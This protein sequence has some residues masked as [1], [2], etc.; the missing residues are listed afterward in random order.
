MKLLANLSWI[1]I[2]LFNFLIVA[3]YG[4]LM[5]YKIGFEFPY[6][7]QKSLLLAHFN[8]GFSGWIS[9]LLMVLLVK[10]SKER[11]LDISKSKFT[12][13][14]TL[15]LICTYG[16]LISF[17]MQGYGLYS[18][19]FSGIASILSLIFS[20]I[21]IKA[22]RKAPHFEA[23]KWF[24]AALIFNIIAVFGFIYLGYLMVSKTLILD[25]YLA[26]LYGYFHFQ[27]NGWFLFVCFGLLIDFL[28]KHSI[29]I[30]S[31]KLIFWLFALSCIPTFGL[32]VLWFDIPI[33]IYTI[34]VIASIAQF[35]GWMKFVIGFVSGKYFSTLNFNWLSKLFMLIVFGA[36]SIKICLQ[37]G[38]TIPEVSKFAFG[39]RPI[40]IA[41][42]HLVFLAI[43]SSFLLAY[44]YFSK[45]IT[46]GKLAISGF[47]V[48]IIGMALNEL[49]LAIQGVGSINYSM[50][51][52]ANEL[53]LLAASLLFIGILLIN[54]NT[55]IDTTRM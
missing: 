51:P 46:F 13:F 33:W 22:L 53:L 18:L 15:Y 54:L 19:L 41:Y 42:L 4:V 48:F 5:R 39:F 24:I 14:F 40:V 27:Y 32:S 2:C 50:I 49:V 44:L 38:S 3:T 16:M 45:F 30:P 20:F 52:F 28:Q 35:F 55:T 47:L 34:I 31:S 17:T 43:I 29:V 1:K 9:L 10:V 11:I 37:L 36:M 7:E 25:A 26:S 23:K 12:L 8:F 6:F 21:F